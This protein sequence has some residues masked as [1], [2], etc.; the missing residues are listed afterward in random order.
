MRERFAGE[1]REKNRN[2]YCAN[3]M[4]FDIPFTDAALAKTPNAMNNSS[5]KCEKRNY[6]CHIYFALPSDILWILIN[7]KYLIF[8]TYL[9]FVCILISV[10]RISEQHGNGHFL[11]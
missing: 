11:N 4:A 5:R 9:T 1:R 3:K 7:N 10:L 2:A 8:Q 6:K